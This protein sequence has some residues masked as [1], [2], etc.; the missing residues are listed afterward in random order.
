MTMTITKKTQ[1]SDTDP[2]KDVPGSDKLREM[3]ALALDSK[4]DHMKRAGAVNYL[5]G[6]VR[7]MIRGAY[8]AEAEYI[9]S[10][11]QR[12]RSDLYQYRETKDDDRIDNPVL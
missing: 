5:T 7:V 3:L 4:Q 6:S 8:S 1:V 10:M 12:A 2:L 11:I 9:S